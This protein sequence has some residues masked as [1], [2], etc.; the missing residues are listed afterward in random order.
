[1]IA[2][3]KNYLSRKKFSSFAYACMI[4]HSICGVILIANT[5]NLKQDRLEKFSCAVDI[6]FAEFKT[7]VEETCFLMY[8]D[9]YNSPVGL[10]TFVLL[11]LGSAAS[12]SV[13]Y[14]L[15][16][17]SRIN[18]IERYSSGR[19]SPRL[20]GPNQPGTR[21]LYVFYFYFFHLVA[22]S[23]CGTLLI[24]LQFTV[25]YPNSFDSKFICVYP[26]LTQQDPNTTTARN[27]SVFA[28]NVTCE[29]L[30]AQDDKDCL[31]SVFGCNFIF[32][33]IMLLEMIYMMR[34][35]AK[36]GRFPYFKPKSWS[37]DWEFIMKYFLRRLH[38][39]GYIMLTGVDTPIPSS[40][41]GEKKVLKAPLLGSTQI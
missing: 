29:N 8:N 3:I 40:E 16:V 35:F 38:M 30:A 18:E 25:L 32:T 24:I 10:F 27:A 26:I 17:G 19:N 28:S 37:C 11:S 21:T 7:Y 6:A 39:P 14:S 1:M 22:R 34:G 41:S 9:V 23:I 36:R 13:I 20:N 12:V 31:L 33:M 15:A 5:A 4:L 2:S